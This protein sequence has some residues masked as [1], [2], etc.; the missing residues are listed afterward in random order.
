MR[1]VTRLVLL[2]IFVAQPL[3]A[4]AQVLISGETGGKK[5]QAVLITA[6][7]LFPKG[8]R[9][10]NAYVSYGYGL[11]KRFDGMISY[12]NITALG[13]TQHYAGLGFNANIAKREK[14]FVDVSLFN[15]LTVPLHRRKEAS[16]L[17]LNSAIVVS[18]PVT[19]GQRTVT[20]YSGVNALIPI[21]AVKDKL[22]TPPET[23]VNV[24]I[25]FSMSLSKNWIFYG[26]IDPGPN[27][28][29]AGVGFLRTF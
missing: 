5:N 9:L 7:G 24:P 10:F 8:L 6:N 17:L 27:L 22:F 18:R 28:K 20:F 2:I 25:G 13:Q 3:A 15:I 16:T 21:G 29:T 23:F 11:G 14:T 12:G 26:E 19:I 4:R 1:L